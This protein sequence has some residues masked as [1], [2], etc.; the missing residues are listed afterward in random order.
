MGALTEYL[1]KE[2]EH[3]RTAVG[4][5]SR[6][7]DEWTT[8]LRSLFSALQQ[9]LTDA[10]RGVGLLGVRELV[11]EREEPRLGF[12]DAPALE[13]RLGSSKALIVPRARY[14]MATIKPPGTELRR[15]EGMVE[16]KDGS[17]A[18]YYLFRLIDDGT[19]RWF[20]RS[21]AQWNSDPEYGNVEELTRDRFEA[22]I[23]RILK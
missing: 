2:A 22:A 11:A 15:A 9:W 10:D 18:D 20:I 6:A 5:Q 14:V 3:L 13:V 12:F 21:V 1:K 17:A 7:V 8:A 16:I 4:E 23:L 19:D